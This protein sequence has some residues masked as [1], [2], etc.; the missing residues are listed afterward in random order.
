MVGAWGLGL[1]FT[2]A[3][4]CSDGGSSSAPPGHGGLNVV[5]TTTVFADIVRNVAGDRATV[6]SIIPPGV[7]PED[8]EPRPDDARKLADARLIVSNGLGLDDFLDELL[9]SAG[10]AD[11]PRLVLGEGVQT[12]V[13]DGQENPHVWLDPSLVRRFYVP[14]ILAALKEVDPAGAATYEANAASYGA[15]LDDLDAE[16][17]A[18]AAEVPEANRKLVTFHDA[19]PYFA[20]HFGFELVGVILENVGQ[21]P[22]ATELAELVERVRAAGATAVFS[23]AQFSPELTETLAEE[24]GVTRV[25]STLYSDALGPA[26][27]DTYVGMMRWNMDQIVEA[28]R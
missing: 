24:A 2:V 21:E 28:L 9:A 4:G 20:E 5:T 16:L 19:F 12:M 13:V 8:F 18:R 10:R 6:S 27:A 25:V 3:A 11:V 22:T 14:A 7:G 23:E 1:V 17:Q 15:A 26:P